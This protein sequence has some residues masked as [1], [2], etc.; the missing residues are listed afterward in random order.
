MKR[1]MIVMMSLILTLPMMAQYG[2]PRPRPVPRAY[3]S[4]ARYTPIRHAMPL[5][6][7]YGLRVGGALSTVNSDDRYLDGGNFRGGLNLGAVVGFQLA[8]NTPVY[9]ETGLYYIEKGGEGKYDGS[10]FTY[11]LNY[12]EVPLLMKYSIYLNPTVSIQPFLGAFVSAGIS[13]KIKDFGHRAAYNSFNN[14]DFK[15]F[16]A[17]LRTGCGVEVD[18]FY[19]EV[20]YDLGLAN[21]C[22]DNFETSHTGSLFATI[23][24]NF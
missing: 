7:Y 12:L 16:D 17:G 10:K 13:G 3:Y 22:H 14:D 21:I 2:R 11:S 9:F 18:H 5:D 4:P 24:V 20:G 1:I 8:Y 6:I 15:R 19:A 23:G